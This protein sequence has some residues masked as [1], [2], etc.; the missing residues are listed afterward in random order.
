MVVVADCH[1]LRGAVVG[2]EE[3]NEPIRDVQSVVGQGRQPG[4]G[5]LVAE[6]QFR[7]VIGYRQIPLL[8]SS[9]ANAVSR[10]PIAKGVAVA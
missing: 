7:K 8:L 2:E 10:K 5:L 1:F 4:S 3:P 9:M 6:R